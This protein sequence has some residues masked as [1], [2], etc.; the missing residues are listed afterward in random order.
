[1]KKVIVL[2]YLVWHYLLTNKTWLLHLGVAL[3]GMVKHI[4]G[5]E[6][7]DRDM[8]YIITF[9]A[10]TM[11]GVMLM[12]IVS[13]TPKDQQEDDNQERYLGEWK[14]RHRK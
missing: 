2:I 14:E 10:G 1:M 12:C 6:G 11:A 9:I 8:G 13:I 7:A 3:V 5:S 4:T